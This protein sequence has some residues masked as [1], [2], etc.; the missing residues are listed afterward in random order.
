MEKDFLS[1]IDILNILM[2]FE[3]VAMELNGK[4]VATEYIHCYSMNNNFLLRLISEQLF[5][6]IFQ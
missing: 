6:I 5:N 3:R 2:D 4:N 1:S